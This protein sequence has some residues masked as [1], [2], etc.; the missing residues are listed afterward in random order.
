MV[1]YKAEGM[2]ES[3]RGEWTV[4]DKGKVGGNYVTSVP[5]TVEIYVG[6]RTVTMTGTLS[7]AVNKGTNVGELKLNG[8]YWRKW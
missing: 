3:R 4:N 1:V 5:I 6:N 2:S 7:Y 8:E